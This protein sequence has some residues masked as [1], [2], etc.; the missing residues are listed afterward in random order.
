MTDYTVNPDRGEV[1]ITFRGKLYPLRPS[2]EAQ[3]AI[4]QALDCSLD[5][6]F[7]RARRYAAAL[8]DAS[9]PTAGI[10]LKLREV[11]AIVAE[12]M[13]AAGKERGDKD[14]LASNA[15]SCAEL[16][17]E[18][19]FAYTEPVTQFLLHALFGGAKPQKKEPSPAP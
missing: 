10:G 5:E 2:Y 11:A 8:E 12:G 7:T 14:L 9:V 17:A 15:D 1:G 19:R 6:L 4:E 3:I 13:K 16:V 18:D